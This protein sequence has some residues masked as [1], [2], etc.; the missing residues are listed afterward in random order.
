MGSQ[1]AYG[2]DFSAPKAA[3]SLHSNKQPAGFES[4][5]YRQN[6]ASLTTQVSFG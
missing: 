1:Q 3:D 5:G 2:S 6:Y 4:S